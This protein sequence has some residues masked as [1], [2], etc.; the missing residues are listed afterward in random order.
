MVKFKPEEQ[1]LYVRLPAQLGRGLIDGVLTS[2]YACPGCEAT[3]RFKAL[4][5]DS[6]D[7]VMMGMQDL[8]NE[9]QVIDIDNLAVSA[10]G[11]KMHDVAES[12]FSYQ[13][14]FQPAGNLDLLQPVSL[15]WNSRRDFYSVP[16]PFKPEELH[17]AGRI[18]VASVSQD[19]TYLV[20]DQ[21]DDD[22]PA[23]WV[24]HRN[25]STSPPAEMVG[26][27]NPEGEPVGV[28]I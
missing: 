27:W 7:L 25:Y 16:Y 17:G 23:L 14:R 11:H 19:N 5:E 1:I 9:M 3:L 26:L 2:Y 6:T 18:K 8:F 21:V 28:G 24:I 10:A 4:F 12:P 20:N 13:D 15:N 22:N